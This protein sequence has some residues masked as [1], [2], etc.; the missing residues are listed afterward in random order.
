M[1]RYIVDTYRFTRRKRRQI[2]L[3]VHFLGFEIELDIRRRKNPFFPPPP[4][5][6]LSRFIREKLQVSLVKTDSCYPST[7]FFSREIFQVFQGR[8]L[9][10]EVF[11]FSRTSFERFPINNWPNIFR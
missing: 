3:K 6:I 9:S 10:E 11:L 2:P 7:R 4:R 5:S 1:C 8:N